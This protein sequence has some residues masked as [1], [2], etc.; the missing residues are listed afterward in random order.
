MNARKIPVS[1]WP[2][3]GSLKIPENGLLVFS[4]ET[5]LTPRRDVARQL[6][7]QALRE[8]LATLLGGK[9]D[10]VPLL[11]VPGQAPCLALPECR[12]GLSVSHEPGLSLVAL[13]LDG[14]VG[15]DLLHPSPLPDALIVARDYLGPKIAGQLA[16]LPKN[17]FGQAFAQAWTSHEARLK[18][19][20]LAL[21][22]WTPEL[23]QCLHSCRV[24]EIDVPGE[25][26]A[27][28]ACPED[29]INANPP[30]VA[31]A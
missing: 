15:I 26:I 10:T 8:I 30:P 5:P 4:V 13:R 23:A 17:T 11:S 19:L 21:T 22:E 3:H 9:P 27:T 29:K 1:R 31:A 2:G 6:V 20:A 18:C 14:A 24:T 25:W 7:R 28:L 12:I 16:S